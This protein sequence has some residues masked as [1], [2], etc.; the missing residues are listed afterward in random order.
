MKLLIATHNFG[1]YKEIASAL[2]GLELEIVNLSDIGITKDIEETGA[3][4]EE[5]AILKARFFAEITGLPTIADDSGIT[6]EALQNEL[7]VKTRRWGAGEKATDEEWL[8]F[9]LKRMKQ[10][11]NKRAEFFTTIAFLKTP[12][13]EPMIFRGACTGIITEKPE[14][15]YL[16]GIP[17]SAVFKPDGL[18]TV[19]SALTS[20]EKNQ[21]S[22]RGKAATQFR[23]H[24]EVQP[25]EK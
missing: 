2:E 19:Y 21:I 8:D 17:L 6:V 10:E 13:A 14:A 22:H 4:Y 7:G 1:K 11:N 24:L 9:F 18:N 5:N 16:K 20:E 25:Q 12:D 3:T 23:K 15:S